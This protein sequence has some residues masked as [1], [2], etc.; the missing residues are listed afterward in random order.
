MFDM[1]PSHGVRSG[2]AKENIMIATTFEAIECDS[3]FLTWLSPVVVLA[4]PVTFPT[5]P[6]DTWPFSVSGLVGDAAADAPFRFRFL[7]TEDPS[8]SCSSWERCLPCMHPFIFYFFA[9]I[10]LVVNTK[11]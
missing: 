3:T 6:L 7:S 9:K 8:P 4:T 2:R 11:K 10:F 5:T 1:F